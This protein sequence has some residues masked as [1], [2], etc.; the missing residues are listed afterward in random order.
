MLWFKIQLI[1]LV[2]LALVCLS[3]AK[4]HDTD[5]GNIVMAGRWA[6]GEYNKKNQANLVFEYVIKGDMQYRYKGD[7]GKYTVIV[8]ATDSDKKVSNQYSAKVH[9]PDISQDMILTSFQKLS[10]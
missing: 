7:G 4:S 8:Q 3:S 10:S 9:E 6:V 2:T 5:D 1:V